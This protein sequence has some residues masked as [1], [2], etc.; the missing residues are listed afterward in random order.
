MA[1]KKAARKTKKYA[2]LRVEETLLRERKTPFQL[3]YFI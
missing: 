3:Q 1:W 2:L